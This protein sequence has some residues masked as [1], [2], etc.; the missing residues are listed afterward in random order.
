MII[1][2]DDFTVL[3]AQPWNLYSLTSFQCL[4]IYL[5]ISCSLTFPLHIPLHLLL[6]PTLIQFF[7]F[8]FLNW[9]ILNRWTFDIYYIHKHYVLLYI[10]YTSAH[11]ISTFSYL[12]KFTQHRMVGR[13][14]RF[15]SPLRASSSFL[16]RQKKHEWT[17]TMYE[18]KN[19]NNTLALLPLLNF[20]LLSK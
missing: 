20:G 6:I 18:P 14:R 12:R 19:W 17:W 3:C 4:L 15:F 1:L 7:L 11:L 8:F 10:F 5:S 16:S 9:P 2:C 13:I